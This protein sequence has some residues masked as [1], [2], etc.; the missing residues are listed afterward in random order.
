MQKR[1]KLS[2]YLEIVA[3]IL[4]ITVLIGAILYYNVFAKTEAPEGYEIGEECPDF[5]VELYK[6]KGNGEDFFTLSQWKGK[7]IVLNFWYIS[8]GPCLAEL[9]HF[10]E[11]QE[12]YAENVK[13]VA[14]HSY[15][16]DTERSKQEFVSNRY[17]D[18]SITFAQDT[19]DL[20]L[21]DHL[22]GKDSYPMSVIL[23]KDG[24]IRYTRQ[25][26]LDKDTLT[27][28]IEKLL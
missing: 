15:N 13:I 24:V 14:L 18:Y 2:V 10:N 5:T 28:E 4:A 9:P 6:N 25:G 19:E 3:W 20:K 27:L 16:V 21:F 23:D 1:T 17:S 7:V 8:C 12:E 26:S 22:G 11:V